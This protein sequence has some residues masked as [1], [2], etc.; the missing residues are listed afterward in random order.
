MSHRIK[1]GQEV[2]DNITGF[3]GVAVCRSEWLHGCE[4]LVVQPPIS[5]DGKLPE[6]GVFDEPQL[7]IVGDGILVKE[8]PPTYGDNT[9]IPTQR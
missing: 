3:R 8:K 2:R 5:K 7:E 1:L 4:R 6:T 9:Y